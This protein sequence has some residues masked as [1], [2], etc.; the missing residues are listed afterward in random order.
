MNMEKIV[1]LHAHGGN[2]LDRQSISLS[3]T[4]VETPMNAPTSTRSSILSHHLGRS[5]THPIPTAW[6]SVSAL[7]V[8]PLSRLIVGPASRERMRGPVTADFLRKTPA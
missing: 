3:L 8:I 6:L 2:L 1:F 5:L 7:V 4:L